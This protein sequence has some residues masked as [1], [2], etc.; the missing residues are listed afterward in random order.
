VVKKYWNTI[1]HIGI[2][3]EHEDWL[4]RRIL[5]SNQFLL[6]LSFVSFLCLF[7]SLYIGDTF[8]VFALIGSLI[9]FTGLFILQLKKYHN[10]SSAL[11]FVFVICFLGYFESYTNFEC[12]NFLYQFP[13]TLA[14]AT[15]FNH[16]KEW[17]TIIF[18]YILMALFFSINIT[19]DFKLF[20]S[21]PLTKEQATLFL[22]R[23]IIICF[24]IQCYFVFLIF[25]NARIEQAML[26]QKLND[27]MVSEKAIQN[28]LNEKE[29][30]V[31]ELHH[32]VKNNLAIISSLLNIKMTSNMNAEAKNVLLESNTRLRSMALIHNRL[33]KSGAQN[34]IDFGDYA[35]ELIKEIQEA[36]A[37]TSST[38][39][40]VTNFK[41][42]LLT[43]NE[44]V[45]CG[46]IL[47]ELLT[48]SLKHAW[49]R[50][51]NRIIE[52]ICCLRGGVF[53]LSVEDNGSGFDKSA[54]KTET[55]GMALIE[56]LCEQI[57]ASFAFKKTTGTYFV[58]KFSA[59]KV[60]IDNIVFIN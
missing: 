45:P 60:N 9:F 56:G 11:G 17:K 54:I 22:W 49:S 39:E 50:T 43:A 23:N 53:F 31:G 24:I 33:Y 4:K 36:Y 26:N 25:K 59:S 52:V 48:N 18:L 14:V 34:D 2:S 27:K 30:I 7:P 1:S 32:R 12:A 42:S 58:M 35:K 21:F 19:T 29:I 44:A 10:F 47:N 41:K 5:L 20:F 6:I 38:I 40:I 8:A 28:A 51:D 16:K 46:L 13:L 37:T 15:V 57:D 3:E 55:M